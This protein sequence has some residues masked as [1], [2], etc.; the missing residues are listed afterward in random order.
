MSRN[1]SETQFNSTPTS[2]TR[3]ETGELNSAVGGALEF[4]A[5]SLR[6]AV[7]FA[8]FLA[9]ALSHCYPVFLPLPSLFPVHWCNWQVDIIP[10]LIGGSVKELKPGTGQ[11]L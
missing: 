3:A 6:E 5:K 8:H 4:A 9:L 1:K 2:P 11:M 7:R 10:P